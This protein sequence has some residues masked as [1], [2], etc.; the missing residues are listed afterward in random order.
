MPSLAVV[1]LFRAASQ[2][3]PRCKANKNARNNARTVT[4]LNGLPCR[5]NIRHGTIW[6][7]P[8]RQ[9]PPKTSQTSA[10]QISLHQS[11]SSARLLTVLQSSSSNPPCGK[12]LTNVQVGQHQK[13]QSLVLISIVAIQKWDS[14]NRTTEL[15]FNFLGN[16]DSIEPNME[17]PVGKL[18][19]SANKNEKTFSNVTWKSQVGKNENN[20]RG[21]DR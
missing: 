6:Q 2:C 8:A 20:Q 9:I 14:G 17:G 4:Y 15:V 1:K 5:S 12:S 11:I 7:D 13:Q 3:R 10:N 18:Q 19:T 16:V 21:Q